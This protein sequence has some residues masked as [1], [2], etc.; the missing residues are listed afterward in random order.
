MSP[1]DIELISSPGASR[2]HRPRRSGVNRIHQHRQWP[3]W[4]PS[5]SAA[6]APAAG[7]GPAGTARTGS[8]AVATLGAELISSP[9]ASRKHRPHRSAANRIGGIGSVPLGHRAC[10]QL[11]RQ[12]QFPAPPERRE[13]DHQPRQW[14]PWAP[15]SS[16][17]RAPAASTGPTG[18]PRTGSQAPA[19][20]TLGTE[21]ISS[22]GASRK[23]RPHRSAAIPLTSTSTGT[24]TGTGSAP[25]V[26]KPIGR[27][28]HWIKKPP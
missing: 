1:S 24:G 11:G 22:P 25:I 17:A 9:G 3:P 14:P 21:L 28:M 8:P 7:T 2:R 26:P 15:S 20:A 12:P 16:A 23:Y 10:R 27:R 13:L 4:A 6:R 18:A 5:S 19:L